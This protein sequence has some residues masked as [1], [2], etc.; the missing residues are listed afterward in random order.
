MRVASVAF[1]FRTTFQRL[2]LA[3]R[4]WHRLSVVIFFVVL[5]GIAVFTAV[6]SYSVFA[7]RI[8]AMPDIHVCDIF[9]QVA[10]EQQH[11][12]VPDGGCSNISSGLVPT[13][14]AELSTTTEIDNILADNDRTVLPTNVP[15]PP[16]GAH[17]SLSLKQFGQRIKAK[18]P[19]YHDIDDEDL[20][21]RV[22]NKYP[23]YWNYITAEDKQSW[24]TRNAPAAFQPMI[25]PQGTIHQIPI[26]SVLEALKAGD[27]RVVEMYD[28][29]GTKR[30]IPEDE[31]Q[32]A[33]K[34]GG[35]IAVPELLGFSIGPPPAKAIE[36]PNGT[37]A[38]FAGT[39]SDDAIKTK[40]N[41]VKLVE[42][43]KSIGWAALFTLAACLFFTYIL[44]AAYRVLLYVI[45]G[46]A[47]QAA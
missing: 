35:K 23:Q 6:V 39:V 32:A 29:Q 40:W 22:L 36:M 42:T 3:K 47:K 10:A 27:K 30:W 5:L 15:L 2:E 28:P 8:Q 34:A 13:A 24:F 25:D 20:A 21:H 31:V 45:F 14:Q 7:P 46:N 43:W 19:V 4:W 33:I 11:Q 44:Q 38:L 18:Y 41:H 16:H 1:P 37:T 26:D 12:T 17:L 9:D